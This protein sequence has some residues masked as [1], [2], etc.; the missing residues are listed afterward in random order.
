MP[1]RNDRLRQRPTCRTSCTTC[2][3]AK[4]PSAAC[5]PRCAIYFSFACFVGADGT[6]LVFFSRESL[7][8]ICDFI[9]KSESRGSA[10]RPKDGARPSDGL[11]LRFLGWF[12]SELLACFRHLSDVPLSVWVF[13]RPVSCFLCLSFVLYGD[14]SF[15]SFALFSPV[16][17]SV[18][19]PQINRL[20]EDLRQNAPLDGNVYIAEE[21][22]QAPH[23]YLRVSRGSCFSPA[24][25]L[26][27]CDC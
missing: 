15:S 20:S 9:Q 11:P 3:S 16:S 17:F 6:V 5:R 23:H 4:T 7:L 2:L 26:K 13:L 18:F 12:T 10:A 1:C 22:H 14:L 21:Y 8:F 19:V 24:N 25:A 27:M